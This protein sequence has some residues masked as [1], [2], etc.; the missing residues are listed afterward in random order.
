[1]LLL[2]FLSFSAFSKESNI[3]EL[4][5]KAQNPLEDLLR[6]AFNYSAIFPY[7]QG[8]G[9]QNVIDLGALIPIKLSEDWLLF[10]RTIL[11]YVWQTVTDKSGWE[12]I[13][14]DFFLSPR[15]EGERKFGFGP[16]VVIPT[17]NN[18]IVPQSW[19]LGPILALAR[20]KGDIVYSFIAKQY[21]SLGN[22]TINRFVLETNFNYNFKDGSYITSAPLILCDWLS[23]SNDT[24]SLPI[25][26][27]FG[28]VI[29]R[30]KRPINLNLQGYYYLT[31]IVPNARWLITLNLQF[32]FPK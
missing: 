2:L 15:T 10:N 30:E 32:L 14:T 4:A 19:A 27:G 25:G 20:T 1:M 9:T 31:M 28:K 21:W 11:P 7:G 12:N 22:A 16:V 24:C 26:M 3:E 17:A 8:E 13:E 5:E 18:N 29:D 6:V 23:T